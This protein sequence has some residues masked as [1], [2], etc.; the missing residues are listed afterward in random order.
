M[1]LGTGLI[2]GFGSSGGNAHSGW[3]RFQSIHHSEY[4]Q[5]LSAI[6]LS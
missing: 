4:G 6:N 2:I 1:D 5:P 3:M